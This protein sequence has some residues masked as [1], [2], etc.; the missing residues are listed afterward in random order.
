VAVASQV[1]DISTDPLDERRR[2]WRALRR[3][4]LPI[5]GV[6]L[7]TAAILGIALYSERANRSGVLN[8]SADLLTALDNQIASAASAYLDPAARTVAV[9][10]DVVKIGSIPEELPTIETL[11]TSLLRRIP[12]IAN[13]SFADEDGNCVM[14]RRG[15][16]GGTDVKLIQAVPGPR[17]VAWIH[18]N[19]AGEEV[20]REEDPTDS[21]DPRTRP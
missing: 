6:V 8:L 9:T 15:P 4:G 7:M 20:G 16:A 5:A 17:R 1:I 10:R 11:G 21:F 3:I 18:R 19:A 2:R 12:Q 14:V 13:L